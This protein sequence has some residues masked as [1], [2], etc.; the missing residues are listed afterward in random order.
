MNVLVEWRWKEMTT[1][2]PSARFYRFDEIS[3]MQQIYSGNFAFVEMQ[4]IHI[5]QLCKSTLYMVWLEDVVFFGVSL[6]TRKDISTLLCFHR[7]PNT[8][9][10]RAA[11]THAL[12]QWG[13]LPLVQPYNILPLVTSIDCAQKLQPNRSY[14]RHHMPKTTK[15]DY[16]NGLKC[17]PTLHILESCDN[18]QQYH[19][20][21]TSTPCIY[22]DIPLFWCL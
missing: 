14:C 9:K 16:C 11:Y 7:I 2:L 21:Q 18:R 17:I 8:Y 12:R 4:F 20:A 3:I 5:N 22:Y 6:S 19:G 1:T 15:F 10:L 13:V